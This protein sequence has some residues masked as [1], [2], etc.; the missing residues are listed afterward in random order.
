M[1]ALVN[2]LYLLLGIVLQVLLFNHL[3]L[4]GG[5][6]WVFVCALIKLPVEW[7]RWWQVVVGFVAGLVVDCFCDTP[8]MHALAGCT[9]MGM[10]VS[11]LHL[12]IASDDVKGGSP[13]I[14]TLGMSVFLRYAVAV[15]LLYCLVLYAVEAFTLFNWT[16]VLLKAG[17]SVAMTLAVAVV[18]EIAENR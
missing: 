16:V 10:R 3:H 2:I 18:W 8:G 6:A 4:W 1:V 5:V 13:S 14:A 11:L 15:V 12:F 17:I 7:P 9:M